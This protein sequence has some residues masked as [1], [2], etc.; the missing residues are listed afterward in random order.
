MIEFNSI[1]YYFILK[2]KIMIDY[3]FNSNN[4]IKLNSIYNLILNRPLVNNYVFHV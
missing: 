4:E 2:L 1:I 3:Y